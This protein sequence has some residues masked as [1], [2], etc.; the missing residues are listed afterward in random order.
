MPMTEQENDAVRELC[1]AARMVVRCET[2]GSPVG[3]T[4]DRALNWLRGAV[5]GLDAL[6]RCP[7]CGHGRPF[8]EPR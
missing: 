1:A 6:T 8:E 2:Q 3:W 4:K 5:E 7:T